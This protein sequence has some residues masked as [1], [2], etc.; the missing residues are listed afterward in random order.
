MNYESLSVEE[1]REV[2]AR[3]EHTI[4]VKRQL[5]IETLRSEVIKIVESRGFSVD[6]VFTPS[7]R[8]KNRKKASRLYVNP[9]NPEITWS[10]RGRKPKWVN[11]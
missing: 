7:I 1:L 11:E 4:A 6:E 2:I 9:G 8:T 3:A 10:G 5:E